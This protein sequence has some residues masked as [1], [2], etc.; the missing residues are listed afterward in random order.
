MIYIIVIHGIATAICFGLAI[1][2]IISDH[3]D[4]Y[5]SRK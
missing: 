4:S 3:K 1:W 5:R 2:G